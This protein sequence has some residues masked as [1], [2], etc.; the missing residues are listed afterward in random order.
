MKYQLILTNE[1]V[2]KNRGHIGRLENTNSYL[3]RVLQN[4]VSLESEVKDL[5]YFEQEGSRWRKYVPFCSWLRSDHDARSKGLTDI[6][7]GMDL[8]SIHE[9]A[10]WD[11]WMGSYSP[12]SNR[13]LELGSNKIGIEN[14]PENLAMRGAGHFFT[15]LGVLTTSEVVYEAL[16]TE[17]GG[18]PIQGLILVVIFGGMGALMLHDTT[19]PPDYSLALEKAQR[20]D[21]FIRGDYEISIS[22]N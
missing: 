3:Q 20:A 8:L 10:Y 2:D 11:S 17:N 22:I 12:Y 9:E 15:S 7:N 4:G 13:I 19:T 6:L 16:T 21:A 1:Q 14:D 5:F 18:H